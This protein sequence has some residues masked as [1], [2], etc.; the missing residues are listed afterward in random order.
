MPRPTTRSKNLVSQSFRLVTTRR[1]YEEAIGQIVEAVRVGDIRIGERLPSERALAELMGV[2]RPT[3]REAI[4]ALADV[5]VLQTRLGGGTVVKSDLIPTELLA[6][7]TELKIGEVA[8]VLEARRL[9]EPRVAQLAALYM[10]EGDLQRLRATIDLLRHGAETR[11]R[12]VLFELRFHMALARATKNTT[13]VELVRTLFRRLEIVRDMAMHEPEEAGR[14][15]AIHERTLRAICA[16]DPDEIEAAM[17]EH[18]SYLERLWEEETG[19]A[20]LRRGLHLLGP[21]P[22]AGRI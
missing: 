21:N 2:S 5:G 11:E 9:L 19:G 6:E 8:G 10:D 3:V 22:G 14:A 20:R 13:I 17:D 4:K 12:F 16:G 7:T 15:I 1:T 18:L